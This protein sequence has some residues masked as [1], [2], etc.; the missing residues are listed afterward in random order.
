MELFLAVVA[1]AVL[2]LLLSLNEALSIDGYKFKIFI[3]HN[4][5]P[6]IVNMICGF[7]LVWFKE[8]LT[9]ILP[10]TG[11]VAVFMGY[12]GHNIIKKIFKVF[13]TR[14]ETYVGRNE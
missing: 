11:L 5:I 7:I 2:Y 3:S 13:D 12:A 14:F 10:I 6:T 9:N 1:G 4:I 8:D